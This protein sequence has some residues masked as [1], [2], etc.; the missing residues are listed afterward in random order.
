MTQKP[1][2]LVASERHI[3]SCHD[4]FGRIVSSPVTSPINFPSKNT[5]MRDGYGWNTNW[6][7]PGDDIINIKDVGKINAYYLRSIQVK[8]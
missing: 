4:S 2:H 7:I 5:S 1:Q 3:S 8:D 6:K